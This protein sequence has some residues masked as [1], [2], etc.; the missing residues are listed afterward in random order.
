MFYAR[1]ELAHSTTLLPAFS[2]ELFDSR[3]ANNKVV[4]T[5][6]ET[7]FNIPLPMLTKL[8]EICLVFVHMMVFKFN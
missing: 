4:S 3:E 6:L 2:G 5:S 1:I 8:L 7:K